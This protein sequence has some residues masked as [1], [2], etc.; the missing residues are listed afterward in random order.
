M[1][2]SVFALVL[3]LTASMASAS[4][5]TLGFSIQFESLADDGSY[6]PIQDV[7]IEKF[8]DG[9]YSKGAWE[10]SGAA[11]KIKIPE[12]WEESS[13]IP[14]NVG[15]EKTELAGVYEFIHVYVLESIRVLDG[16][17]FKADYI[18]PMYYADGTGSN[19]GAFN[20]DDITHREGRID[21]VA[22]FVLAE[23]ALPYVSTRFKLSRATR[24][25][26]FV[27]F[28]PRDKTA[29]VKVVGQERPAPVG[30]PCQTRYYVRGRWPEG[31]REIYRY[32]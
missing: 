17:R 11:L 14:L 15:S 9:M 23:T 32:E 26:A 16:S 7:S 21:K 29:P 12:I 2:V 8:L 24:G 31:M 27:V 6:F 18:S 4:A 19:E 25:E 1:K 13:T 5:C 22:G 10:Y 20:L 30:S 3:L 28:V